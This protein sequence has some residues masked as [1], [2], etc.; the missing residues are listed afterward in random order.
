MTTLIRKERDSFA[1]GCLFCGEEQVPQVRGRSLAANLGSLADALHY[2]KL[3]IHQAIAQQ[4]W[5]CGFG[6]KLYYECN[7]RDEREF[8]EKLRYVHRNPVKRGLVK[9]AADWKW[10]SLRHY[11]LCEIGRVEIESQSTA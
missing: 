4:N 1:Y 3:F 7:V 9:Q 11:A 10:S 6:Q 8:V 5:F 2:L